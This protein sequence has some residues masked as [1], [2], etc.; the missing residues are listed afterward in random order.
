VTSRGKSW[1]KNYA[2]NPVSKETAKLLKLLNIHRPGLNFYSLRRTFE[3]IAGDS[4]DQVAV[5]F[6]MG[7]SPKSSDMASIYRQK[8][9]DDRLRSVTDHVHAWLFAD[10]NGDEVKDESKSEPRRLRVVG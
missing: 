9:E 1:A 8:I 2:D 7:H 4:R 10:G 5:D 3:T 6:L